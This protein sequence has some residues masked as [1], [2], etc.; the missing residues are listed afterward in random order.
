[1]VS[2]PT[3][4]LPILLSA[5]A[6]FV[7]SS[8]MHMVL[9]YH[10][11]DVR[12]LSNEDDTLKAFRALGFEP[13]DYAV[14]CA[15]SARE[16]KDPEY[17]DKVTRGPVVFMTVCQGGPSMGL[18]LMLWFGYALAVGVFAA[19]VTGRALGPGASY[20]PVFRFAGT[21]AFLAYSFALLQHSIWYQR[22]WA[23]TARSMADGLV[24]A[25]LTAGF[26]GWL[27]P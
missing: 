11:H 5:V 20:L 12:K 13:G 15:E 10:K 9:G 2:I 4:W 3:L 21:T 7:A 6:V 23:T 16:L 25:A 27:W 17:I 14:P 8:V 26:F 18:S 19:Y 1:M 24:Y 22:S